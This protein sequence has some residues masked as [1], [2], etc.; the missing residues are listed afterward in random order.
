MPRFLLI[1]VAY[2]AASLAATLAL[3]I[4]MWIDDGGE[5]SVSWGS[6]AAFLSRVSPIVAGVAALTAVPAILYAEG[7]ASRRYR[8]YALFGV[9]AGIAPY[10]IGLLLFGASA[11]LEEWNVLARVISIFAAAGLVGGSVYWVIAGRRAGSWGP[12]SPFRSPEEQ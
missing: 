1:L 6:A 5:R 12:N 2:I 7:Y 9:V 3:G 4:G 11:F 10:S 8:Y